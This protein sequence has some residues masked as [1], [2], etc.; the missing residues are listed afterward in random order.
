MGEAEIP[1]AVCRI[2]ARRSLLQLR[3]PMQGDAQVNDIDAFRM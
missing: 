3:G 1:V 2:W